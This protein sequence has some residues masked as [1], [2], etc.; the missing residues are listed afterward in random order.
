M[1]LTYIFF[2]LFSYIVVDWINRGLRE[3]I[4]PTIRET[5]GKLKQRKDVAFF[6][7]LSK[8]S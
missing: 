6:S 4:S 5:D 7:H 1:F 8:I 2:A 3:P